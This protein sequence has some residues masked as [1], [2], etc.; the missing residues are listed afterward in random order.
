VRFSLK[1]RIALIIFDLEAVMM[2]AVLWATLNH[3]ENATREQFAS[4]ERAILEIVSG[5][6]HIAIRTG[7]YTELQPYLENL[8]EDTRI[9][10]VMLV[11]SRGIV[12]ASTRPESVGKFPAIFSE[13]ATIGGGS[14][15]S[16][17]IST[18]SS[19]TLGRAPET[20]PTRNDNSRT[21]NV[22]LSQPR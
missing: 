20:L 5:I 19:S 2:T 12:V 18:P 16:I 21:V 22:P 14:K 6:S 15:Y 13:A 3:L 4:S 17:E 1:Y 11:D 7:E 8:L 9:E 10:Q